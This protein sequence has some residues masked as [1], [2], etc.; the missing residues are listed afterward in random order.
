MSSRPRVAVLTTGRQDFGIVRSTIQLLALSETIALELWAGGM[1]LSASHGRTVERL[2]ADEFLVT[3][4]IPFPVDDMLSGTAAA[5]S[6][7]GET[8]R[9]ARPDA[10]MLVGDR[11]ETAAAALAA[12]ILR[13]PVVHLHGGEETEGAI[14]NALRHAI[15]KLSALHLV[16]HADHAARVVQ[17]GEDP[18]RVIVVGAPGLD[19]LY[20]NDLPTS[21]TVE[22]RL[23][24][25]LP[26]PILL[27]T[28]HPATLSGDTLAEVLAVS[29]A[30]EG[31]GGTIV[32]TQPNADAGGAEIRAYW[33][34]WAVGRPNVAVVDALGEENYWAL[35]RRCVAVVG[36]SSSGLIEAPAAGVPSINV[37][38]RQRGRLRSSSTVDVACDA[39]EVRRA[40]EAVLT[41]EALATAKNA[42]AVYPRGTAAPRIVRALEAWLPERSSVKSFRSFPQARAFLEA[43]R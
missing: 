28:V 7:V 20:R 34:R 18:S 42:P 39:A 3:R 12:V 29:A 43:A 31:F 22:T 26:D 38:D 30:L 8:L 25:S 4:E 11:W 6:A 1:H 41:P 16:S 32:V 33:R 14:D 27:V 13:V 17:M 37:G 36:N 40:L 15:T 19:N 35:L 23:G 2:R 9:D 5:L 24:V 21:E 10:L